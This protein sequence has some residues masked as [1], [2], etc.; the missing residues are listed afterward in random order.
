[1]K[2]FEKVIELKGGLVGMNKFDRF[3]Y[4]EL[5]G[6][7][8]GDWGVY[9][10]GEIISYDFDLLEKCDD[11]D[12]CYI[13]DYNF[14]LEDNNKVLLEDL[15]EYVGEGICYDG[16]NWDDWYNV[17]F[18]DDVMVISFINVNNI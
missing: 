9:D 4:C 6:R 13:D 3:I 18:I 7:V 2:K 11:E 12:L 14:D 17:E 15:K 1:M 8:G 10:D 16:G 5:E